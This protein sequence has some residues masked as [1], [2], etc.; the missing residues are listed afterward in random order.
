MEL[1]LT[2][3]LA[4]FDI[5]STGIRVATDRII[6]ISI[7]KVNPDGKEDLKTY[8]I[9]PGIPIPP[10]S[11]AIHG[12]KDEDVKDKPTFSEIANELNKL[13]SNCDLAGYNSNKFD[14]PLLIEEFLRA[15]INFDYK[16][17]FLVDVQNI[18]HKMEPRTL[19]GAYK[20]FC[21]KELENA[22]RAE[23]DTLAT[24]EVLKSQLDMYKDTDFKDQDGK[25]TRPVQNDVKA[26][27]Q[28]S[29]QSNFIDLVGH[30]VYNANHVEVFNFGKYKGE[31]VE[32]VF[33]KE[34][35]YYD[36]MMRAEFPLSTKNAI[37]AIKLKGFNK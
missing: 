23:V 28:F 9:N 4:F 35:Q 31:P 6:E 16:N 25:V 3:P 30:I 21:N 24:Y 26:L 17:R 8:L 20:F 10:A 37:T 19:R 11:T 36:W 1:N 32:E 15:G 22:H 7:L 13:L 2:R 27:H 14:I 18:F 5:E 34:P 12:I 29:Y 33:R